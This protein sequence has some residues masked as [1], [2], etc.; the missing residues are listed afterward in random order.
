MVIDFFP[1]VPSDSWQGGAARGGSR[2]SVARLLIFIAG[3]GWA[4][5]AKARQGNALPN[6]AQQVS[7]VRSKARY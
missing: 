4:R 1:A 3:H 5:L 7:A 2:R 6:A